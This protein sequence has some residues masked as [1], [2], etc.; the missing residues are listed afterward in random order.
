MSAFDLYLPPAPFDQRV[1]ERRSQPP[2]LQCPESGGIGGEL[3]SVALRFLV[4]EV[5]QVT[6]LVAAVV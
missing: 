4:Q 5:L 2:I 1:V 6:A 3:G